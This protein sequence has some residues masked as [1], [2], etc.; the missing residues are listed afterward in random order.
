[1]K[2][3]I[4]KIKKSWPY[5]V[6]AAVAV[7]FFMVM[8]FPE[9]LVTSFVT[10]KFA[11]AF[12]GSEMSAETV[13]IT[14]PP[15]IELVKPVFSM[16]NG[17]TVSADSIR[18]VPSTLSLL[19]ISRAFRSDIRVFGGNAVARVDL[20]ADFKDM[21]DINKFDINIK[22]ADISRFPASFLMGYKIKGMLDTEIDLKAGTKGH[23][24]FFSA[25]ISQGSIGI[26]FLPG[27]D[28][29]PSTADL[30]GVIK[31]DVAD[32]RKGVFKAG[33]FSGNISGTVKLS[34]PS[35][36]SALNLTLNVTRNDA[37][38]D[39]G[40]LDFMLPE[41]VFKTGTTKKISVTG[42]VDRPEYAF[43]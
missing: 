36:K 21:Q 35:G 31:E 13:K 30:E 2:G 23:D 27:L 25:R 18:L 16:N 40:G 7:I 15:G 1:M 29:V 32:I 38:K 3:F 12:H 20:K 28:L 9:K 11:T 41:V 26:P 5:L 34:F 43:K 37:G 10:K 6:Y 33:I 19:G 4:K 22:N 24:G 8:F 42:T 17:E 39:S 14:F